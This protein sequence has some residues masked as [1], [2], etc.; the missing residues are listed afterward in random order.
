M[1]NF[2]LIHGASHGAWCWR[3]LI[4]ELEARNHS[5]LAIDLPSH[6]ADATAPQDV[7]IEDYVAA[8]IDA[9]TEDMILVGHSLGGLTV[10]LAADRAPQKVRS[11]VYL[12]AWVPRP[13]LSL[14]EYRSEGIT[15]AL[16]DATIV[17]RERGVTRPKPSA[18]AEVF[19]TDC[20]P[21]ILAFAAT[22]LSPQPIAVMTE[23]LHFDPLQMPRH[24]IRCLRD[25]AIS[26]DYQRRVSADWSDTQIHEIDSGHSP[27][28]S[29]PAKLAEILDQIA[30][31]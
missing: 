2:L 15:D 19:Y 17:D 8:A 22:R 28:F 5:V 14:A 29:H 7:G 9:L 1:A 20:S 26:P 30:K 10:T 11:V 12:C 18:A 25:N 21:D 31:T 13:G 6:G 23:P 27:F 16:R 4:P 3:D 24:Y